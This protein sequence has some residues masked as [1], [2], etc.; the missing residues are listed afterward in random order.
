MRARF[1]VGHLISS[2]GDLLVHSGPCLLTA[3]MLTGLG[4]AGYIKVY[5]GR[6]TTGELK[7]IVNTDDN[8]TYCIVFGFPA[9]FDEGLYVAIE[10]QS[11]VQWSVQYMPLSGGWPV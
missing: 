4:G 9:D 11:T 6:N 8:E 5:D 3:V 1:P 7:L 2:D 10:G